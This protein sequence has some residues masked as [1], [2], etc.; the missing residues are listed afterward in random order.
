MK[1][2]WKLYNRAAKIMNISCRVTS[3]PFAT[4]Y[5]KKVRALPEETIVLSEA[6]K[7]LYNIFLHSWVGRSARI[8]ESM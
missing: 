2:D 7:P 3:P 6:V 5:S 8:Q 4:P 1:Q